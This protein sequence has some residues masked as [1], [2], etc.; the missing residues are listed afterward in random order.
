MPRASSP[1]DRFCVRHGLKCV[2]A[3]G[4]TDYE[5]RDA[6][7]TGIYDA[8]FAKQ[9]DR[10]FGAAAPA[11]TPPPP[12]ECKCRQAT[13]IDRRMKAHIFDPKRKD[14]LADALVELQERNGAVRTYV[15]PMEPIALP[16]GRAS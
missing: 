2:W 14:E 9:H 13:E 15:Q 16:P 1:V 10:A 11:Y 6:R 3:G 7:F 12:P 4:D 5:A 8:F